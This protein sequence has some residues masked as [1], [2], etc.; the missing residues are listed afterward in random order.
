MAGIIESSAVPPPIFG[1]INSFTEGFN[2]PMTGSWE[3]PVLPPKS[4]QLLERFL[5]DPFG[6]FLPL[7]EPLFLAPPHVFAF[8]PFPNSRRDS[9]RD[10]R[11]WPPA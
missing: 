5:R 11:R 7:R 6:P 1:I 10:L 2:V 8:F 9:L 4:E 3:Y